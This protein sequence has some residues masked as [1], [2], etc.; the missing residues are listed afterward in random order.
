MGAKERQSEIVKQRL[1]YH[2]GNTDGTWNIPE[3]MPF[4]KEFLNE[5]KKLTE[6]FPPSPTREGEGGKDGY[7]DLALKISRFIH[8]ECENGVPHNIGMT[9]LQMIKPPQG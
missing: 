5:V 4:M 3:G 1:K 8:D 2:F 6:S 9:V 7:V